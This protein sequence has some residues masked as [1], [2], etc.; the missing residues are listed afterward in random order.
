KFEEQHTTLVTLHRDAVR[1]LDYKKKDYIGTVEDTY[2]TQKGILL[3]YAAELAHQNQPPAS[4]TTRTESTTSRSTLPRI[5][6]PQF[7]G[8]Y[9]DWPAFRDLFQSMI[10]R[11]SNLSGVEKL[12][13]LKIVLAK[14]HFPA[15]NE[16]RIRNRAEK[17]SPW[18]GLHRR[19]VRKHWS[20]D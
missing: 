19:H 4:P 11:D 1:N 8:K 20:S 6:L 17:D 18:R 12:H 7:S 14:I 13:Y 3:D 9:E 16:I 2:L 5:Q 10:D 15:E